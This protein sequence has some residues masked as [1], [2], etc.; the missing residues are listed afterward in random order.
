MQTRHPNRLAAVVLLTLLASLPAAGQDCEVPLFV[1]QGTVDANVMILFDNSGSMNEVMFHPDYDAFATYSGPFT[2]TRTYYCYASGWY[3]PRNVWGR[4]GGA[5]HSSPVI[6]MTRGFNQYGRYRGNYLNWLFYHA[7]DE[8][9]AWTEHNSTTRMHVAHEVVRDIIQNSERVRF[10]LTI[11]NTYDGGR[12]IA[13]CGSSEEDLVDTVM[14]IQGTTWTPL[15]ETMEDILDYYRGSDSPII[16]ECQKNF[17][18]VITDGF[19]TMDRSVSGY[20]VDADGDGRDPGDCASI[21]S[22]DPNSNDCSDHMD[23]VAYYMYDND[24]SSDH[25]DDQN[26]VTYTIG[27]GVDATILQ[28]TADNGD[29]LYFMASDA[30]DLWTSLELVMLDIISRISTGAAVAVVST[31][32]GYEDHLYRGKFMPGSWN[33]YLESFELPYEDGDSP[34]WEA[35]YRL[36]QRSANSRS[37]MT[38]LGSTAYTFDDGSASDLMA[39]MGIGDVDEASDVIRWTRGE[40]VDDLRHRGG[41]KLGDIIH[42]TPV[43]V[44]APAHFNPDPDYQAFMSAH[45]NR[46]KVVY[47][48]ANDGMLHAFLAETGEE[49]WAFVPEFALP[50]LAAIADT[51]YCHTY[52]VDLTPTVYDCKLGGSW[53]TVLVGGGRQGGAGYFALDVTDPYGPDLMWQVELPNGK[54][55]ASEVA[56]AVIDGEYV[57]LMGSGLDKTDGRAYL[58][59]YAVA[60]GTHLGSV[61]LS[62]DSSRRNRATAPMVMDLELDG[63]HDCCYIADLHGYVHRIDFDGTTNVGNWDTRVLWDSGGD[64]IT[65]MPVTAFG[66]NG[67]VHVYVGTGA[68]LEDEDIQTRDD[69]RFVCLID[70]DDSAEYLAPVDQTDAIH[71]IAGTDGWYIRLEESP[72]E[73]VTEPAVV[74]AGAVFFTTYVPSSDLCAAGG[75]SWLYR[76]DYSNGDVPDDGEDDDWD[77]DRVQSLGDGVASRPVVDVVN[78]TVIVQSSDTTIQVEEIGQTF[79]HLTVRSWQENFDYVSMP[80]EP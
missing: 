72:G 65:A 62:S 42:S 35:G 38:G 73:R 32:R 51:N 45:E 1:Q 54:P 31:E 74:V 33:G 22:P 13:E 78:E 50:K 48:G 16:A 40:S 79:F 5:W 68:Y 67:E 60:D 76:L 25:P 47:A 34:V 10:G 2:T 53:R 55:F 77:G 28:D 14:D 44:G 70:R 15:G 24:M 9:R 12:V 59:A 69:H 11:F 23:D 21:G 39:A 37:I 46:T 43:V 75:S 26:V 64:E 58:E 8:Q 17:L 49:M 27:F 63:E 61:L 56:F 20:L 6:Y 7:T 57:A 18:I 71:D 19:P 36:A 29:G 80:S 4:P 3:A 30:V 66:E 52:T 41:W